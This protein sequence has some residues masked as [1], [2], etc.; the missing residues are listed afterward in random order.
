M[1]IAFT[2]HSEF[3]IQEALRDTPVVFIAGPRQV[4]KT[5]ITKQL[6]AK[7]K[8]N[9]WTYFTFDD[10]AQLEIARNDPVGFIRHLP[11]T[12]IAIDE[13][14]RLPELFLAIKQTVDEQRQN[15]R[16]LLTGSANAL[17]LPKLSDALTGRME[18]VSL[19]ALSECEILNRKPTFLSRL[20]NLEPLTA[21]NTRLR[22]HIIDRLVTGCFPVPLLRTSENR[23]QSWYRQYVDM[24]IQSDILEMS[25]IDYPESMNKLL[26]ALAICSGQLLNLNDLGNRLDLNLLTVKKYVGMLEQLYLVQRIPAWHSNEYKRLV[27]APKVNLIDT[28]LICAIRNLNS[29]NLLLNPGQFGNV[30]ESF[31]CNELYKQAVWLS[32][33]VSFSHYRDKDKVEVDLIIENSLGECFAIETKASAT[34]HKQDFSSLKR[35]RNIAGQRFRIGILLYD[36]DHTTS[37]GDDMFAVPIGALWS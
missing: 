29:D 1:A 28:R 11:A 10:Q 14:Q 2:R 31:V 35:F 22:D 8:S 15:G 7:G 33:R 23:R 17:L 3:M 21:R 25:N 27:K 26:K 32:E 16:F 34:L 37:F 13:V 4:G 19:M 30:L 20:L 18:T 5:T 6:I 36:G 24:M 12:R 9:E